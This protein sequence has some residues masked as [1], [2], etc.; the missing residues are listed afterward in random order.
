MNTVYP[1]TENMLRGVIECNGRRDI[2]YC[3]DECYG[4][5][6]VNPVKK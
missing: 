2:L 4:T 5:V 3:T 6:L 1:S